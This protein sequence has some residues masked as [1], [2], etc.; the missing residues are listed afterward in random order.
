MRWDHSGK[1]VLVT[2]GGTGIGRATAL[3][4]ARAGATVVVAG[5]R[6]EPLA[7]TVERIVEA[8]GRGIAVVADVTRPADVARLID[9]AASRH[10]G[11]DIAFNNAGTLGP[12]GPLAEIEEADGSSVVATNLTGIWLAMKYEIR[13]MREYGG[14][15]III[16][17]SN[18]GAH[19][20]APGLGV[21]GAT[22]AAVR[23]LTR[24]AAREYIGAGI[25]INSISPGPIDTPMSRAPGESDAERDA[26]YA[27]VIPVGRVGTVEEVAATVLWLASPEAGYIVGHDLV[28]DGGI[29]A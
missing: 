8:G 26:R 25:R 20:T 2:G 22:K 17:A 21:Y 9:T 4:F 27:A 23:V 7:E 29:S 5:R 28:L 12:V 15:V 11:L 16:T 10:G 24:S 18:L 19:V 3:A 1:V 6:P 14:G 13:Y